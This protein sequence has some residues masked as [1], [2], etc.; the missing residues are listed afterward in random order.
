M[1]ANSDIEARGRRA[2]LGNFR[3]LCTSTAKDSPKW[4]TQRDKWKASPNWDIARLEGRSN[5]FVYAKYWDDLRH[6]MDERTYMRKVLALEIGPEHMIYHSWN[7]DE[8]VRPRPQV[9]ALDVTASSIRK[10]SNF[11]ILAGFDP[12]KIQDVTLFLKAYQVP[13][14][15][16]PHWWVIDEVTT[17]STT[18]EEHGAAVLERLRT[19]WFANFAPAVGGGVVDLQGK[20]VHIRMDPNGDNDQRPDI[21]VYRTLRKMGLDV[22]TAAFSKTNTTRGRVPKEAGIAMVNGLLKSAAGDR[23]LFVDCDE[24][25]TPCAPGLV[26]ALELSERNE[27]GEAETKIKGKTDL[28]HWPA[29]LRYALWPFEKVIVND[30]PWRGVR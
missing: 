14:S 7:R 22:M 18:P 11:T 26:H 28:S 24:S 15:K 5:P 9:G 19:K 23:R 20:R 21:S 10:G 3:R 4:R 8:N 1:N 25:R 17:K 29:S 30:Q 12:G 6:E 27:A 13:G 16:L 2:P